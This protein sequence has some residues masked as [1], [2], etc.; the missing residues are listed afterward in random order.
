MLV[1]CILA[2]PHQEMWLPDDTVQEHGDRVLD[3]ML[4]LVAQQAGSMKP[5]ISCYNNASFVVKL[6]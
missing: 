1:Q 6:F 5:Y 4:L 2:L 3:K